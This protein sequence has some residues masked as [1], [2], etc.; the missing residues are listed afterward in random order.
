PASPEAEESVLFAARLLQEGGKRKQARSRLARLAAKRAGANAS[1]ARWTL[2]WMSRQDKLRDAP[3]RFAEFAASAAGDEERAQGL[4]WQARASGKV[5]L[6]QRAA[7]LDPLGWYGLLARERLG[8]ASA[9]AAPF[10][11]PPPPLV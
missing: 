11:P 2:A 6:F 4:Y 10:P 8:H 9:G 7:D 3:E 1:L 5:S